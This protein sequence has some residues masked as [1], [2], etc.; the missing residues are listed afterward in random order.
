MMPEPKIK[1]CSDCKYARPSYRFK[2]LLNL[3]SWRWADCRHPESGYTEGLI[4]NPLVHKNMKTLVMYTSCTIMRARCNEDRC[5]PEGKWFEKKENVF[6][7]L[8]RRMCG[9]KP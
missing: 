6:R 8:M 1:Y 7:R 5:G 2:N 4:N 9:G 3:W